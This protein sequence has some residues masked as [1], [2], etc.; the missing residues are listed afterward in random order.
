M[1]IQRKHGGVRI[2]A[3]DATYSEQDLLY[4]NGALL[5]VAMG[6]QQNEFKE[7]TSTLD[8]LGENTWGDPD[9]EQAFIVYRLPETVEATLKALARYDGYDELSEDLTR[10]KRK[11]EAGVD[12]GE[13]MPMATPVSNAEA[14]ADEL[15]AMATGSTIRREYTEH[16]KYL[17]YVAQELKTTGGTIAG[18]RFYRGDLP[19]L[20][21]EVRP[22]SDRLQSF[23]DELD[24]D[25]NE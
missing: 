25:E 15:D 24:G 8:I 10:V 16:Q 5:D 12:E 4:P 3:G 1:T 7:L 2:D 14:V 23:A 17:E 11:L 19:A 20:I 6:D 9:I 21:D 18:S 22:D 13:P